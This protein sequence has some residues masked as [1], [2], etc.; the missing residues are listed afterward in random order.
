MHVFDINR[1]ILGLAKVVPHRAFGGHLEKMQNPIVN[2]REFFQVQ[3]CFRLPANSARTVDVIKN[4]T[5]YVLLEIEFSTRIADAQA[6]KSKWRPLKIKNGRF[7]HFRKSSI[8]RPNR[9][10]SV[11]I[12]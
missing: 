5:R 3:K 11:A 7:F 9:N 4:L 1:I 6:P 2:D 8:F 10:K 12:A